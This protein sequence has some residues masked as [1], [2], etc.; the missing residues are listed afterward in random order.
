[1][2][3]TTTATPAEGTVTSPPNDSLAEAKLAVARASAEITAIDQELNRLA[4]AKV[5]ATARFN[6]ACQHLVRLKQKEA[7][8]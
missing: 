3:S 1:M 7:I 4:L 6:F 8:A 2:S 5:E